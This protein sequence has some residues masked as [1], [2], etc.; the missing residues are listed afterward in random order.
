M[1]LTTVVIWVAQYAFALSILLW[2]VYFI[3]RPGQRVDLFVLSALAFPLALAIALLLGLAIYD[4]RPFVVAHSVPLIAH[5]ADNGF[6]SDHTLLTAAIAAVVFVLNRKL[7]L[8]LFGI[9][10]AVGLARIAALLHSP[11]GIAG[12]LLI[13]IVATGVAVVGWK[14]LWPRVHALIPHQGTEDT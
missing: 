1:A 8:V 11:L 7:G 10:L 5:T 14:K 13:A 3:V 6:P 4:P 2:I 9:S 12:S